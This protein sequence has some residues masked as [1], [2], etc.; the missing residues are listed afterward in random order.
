MPR[1]PSLC[2]EADATTYIF[3]ADTE[4]ALI[5]AILLALAEATHAALEKRDPVELRWTRA[6]DEAKGQRA[7]ALRARARPGG[8]CRRTLSSAAMECFS[9]HAM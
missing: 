9:V 6:T 2:S 8:L 1:Q 4:V 5:V 3:Q 7:C